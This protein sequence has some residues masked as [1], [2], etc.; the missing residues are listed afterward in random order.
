[1]DKIKNELF[2]DQ[3]SNQKDNLVVFELMQEELKKLSSQLQK[4]RGEQM[5]S[6]NTKIKTLQVKQKEFIESQ[7]QKGQIHQ[8]LQQVK[9]KL[10][11]QIYK[12]VD[13]K[14]YQEYKRNIK[15]QLEEKTSI[16]EIQE[17]LNASQNDVS[18]RFIEFKQQIQESI[19]QLAEQLY[20]KITLEELNQI[21]SQ[22]PD[23]AL[24]QQLIEAKFNFNSH[25]LNNSNNQVQKSQTSAQQIVQN[26]NF[27]SLN[28][29]QTEKLS[30]QFEQIEKDVTL[31][32]SI[33]DICSL[34]DEKASVDEVTK[35]LIYYK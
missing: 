19:D 8:E 35:A 22:K 17:A 15:N 31:K 2:K 9:Q 6:I 23:L 5:S 10:E 29:F 1:M 18:N 21:M 25:K 13:K 3:K 34:L 12:K 30:N 4:I 16:Q 26:Q 11:E 27:N 32:A 33:K 20:S 28:N 24:V 7:Q 14:E